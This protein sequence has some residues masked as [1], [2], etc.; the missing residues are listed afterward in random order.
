MAKEIKVEKVQEVAELEVGDRVK[1]RNTKG[2]I[3][4]IKG[5]KAY[6]END[7][8]MKVQVNLSDLSRSGNPPPP[9]IPSK[10]ATVS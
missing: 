6:I 2:T 8:G 10:K 1:Y 3:V 9:K 4:S 5:T 7:M